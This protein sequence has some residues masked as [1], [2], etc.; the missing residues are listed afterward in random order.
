MMVRGNKMA[1]DLH[2][3]VN[4]DGIPS[5]SITDSRGVRSKRV[6]L[7]HLE[8]VLVTELVRR[9]ADEGRADGKVAE[10]VEP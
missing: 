8:T 1:I 5:A 9:L 3:F 4:R 10:E 6:E 2:M 7:S